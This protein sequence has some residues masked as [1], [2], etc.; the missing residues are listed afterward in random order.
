MFNLLTVSSEQSKKESYFLFQSVYVSF[1]YKH[2]LPIGTSQIPN[3]EPN[4][5][6]LD[7]GYKNE[8]K[9]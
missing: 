9:P 7:P 1:C 5:F 6:Y 4:L 8:R 3:Q 2:A